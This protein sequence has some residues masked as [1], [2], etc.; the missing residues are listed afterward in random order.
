M[1][2][3]RIQEKKEELISNFKLIETEYNETN[4]RLKT[5]EQQLLKFAG[6]IEL[7]TSQEAE[8]DSEEKEEFAK[9]ELVDPETG[10]TPSKSKA[11]S[12]PQ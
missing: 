1:N 10:E 8:L 9:L 4:A 12:R 11:K 3:Q 2:K 6:A 5:L 7:I